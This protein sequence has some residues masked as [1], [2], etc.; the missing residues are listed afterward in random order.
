MFSPYVYLTNH[1]VRLG[2]GFAIIMED[3]GGA[4]LKSFIPPEGFTIPTF[5]EIAGR[6][7]MICSTFL[8]LPLPRPT[9]LA[10][11]TF[12]VAFS[13]ARL[14]TDL[15]VQGLHA[16]HSAGVTHQDINPMNIVVNME[17]KAL[18]IIDFGLA[19]QMH[20]KEVNRS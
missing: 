1:S 17:T 14:L 3:I 7:G 4:R 15:V 8:W 19:S 20:T 9:S 2:Y 16:V 13:S 11:S 10:S 5:I 18:N 12:S 6:I